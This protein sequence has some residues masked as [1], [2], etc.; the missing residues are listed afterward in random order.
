MP[1]YD[2]FGMPKYDNFRT[3]H[4]TWCKNGPHASVNC[5]F[6][7]TVIKYRVWQVSHVPRF[8][9]WTRLTRFG[10]VDADLGLYMTLKY[11]EMTLSL[12][13]EYPYSRH[14]I[15]L[16]QKSRFYGKSVIPTYVKTFLSRTC[17]IDILVLEITLF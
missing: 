16:R 15:I 1:N 12:T 13:R 4:Q 3:R 7:K 6:C 10:T 17:K 2:N 9:V 11:A 5:F 8:S 14:I